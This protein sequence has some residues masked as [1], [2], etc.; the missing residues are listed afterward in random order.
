MPKYVLGSLKP[1]EF[2][3]TEAELVSAAE[4]AVDRARKVR[5]R[6]RRKD[7]TYR[8]KDIAH[9]R[10]LLRSAARPVKKRLMEQNFKP[11]GQSERLLELSRQMKME[12]IALT[13]MSKRGTIPG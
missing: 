8:D 11:K 6:H 7:R 9:A 1:A 5:K 2:G 3:P 10:A 13:K 12:R 4:S